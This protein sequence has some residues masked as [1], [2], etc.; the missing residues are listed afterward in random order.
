[1]KLEL[2]LIKKIKPILFIIL[3]SPSFYWFINLYLGNMGINP[4]DETIRKLGE[5]SL[6]LLILTLLITP[7]AKINS[8]RNLVSLR[9]MIGLFAFYY[10]CLHLSSYIILDHFFNWDFILK[11]V[12]K[13]PFIT[14]GFSS[15]LLTIPLALTSN[16]ILVRKL[17]YKIWKRIHKLI[18]IIAPL[19]SLHYFLLTKADKTEPLVY[20]FIII[21]LLLF[22]LIN[23]LLKK[24]S[25]PR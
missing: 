9:R 2:S 7:I 23:H 13:R 11:D 20:I 22:R 6:R 21:L 15:F 19:A 25:L 8:L 18:Y 3:I 17:T 16:N 4:I 10:I 24:G 1:M 5:F 14:L 12:Y